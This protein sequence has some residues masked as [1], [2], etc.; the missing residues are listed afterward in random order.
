MFLS[1]FRRT[2]IHLS[3]QQQQQQHRAERRAARRARGGGSQSAAW[4]LFSISEGFNHRLDSSAGGGE[5]RHLKASRRA[6][7][8]LWNRERAGGL[9]HQVIKTR[10]DFSQHLV[11]VVVVVVCSRTKTSP[12]TWMRCCS[13]R[14]VHASSQEYAFGW[15]SCLRGHAWLVF[16]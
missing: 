15:V 13:C 2:S 9:R 10:F 16:P 7:M 11:V 3:L 8:V 12:F 14:S 5:E 1:I 6:K 4:F